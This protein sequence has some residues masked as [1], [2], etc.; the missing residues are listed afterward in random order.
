MNSMITPIDTNNNGNYSAK[1]QTKNNSK[2]DDGFT[3]TL[4][5]AINLSSTKYLSRGNESAQKSA[6]SSVQNSKNAAVA[7]AQKSQNAAVSFA[8]N[9]KNAG[10]SS[11]NIKAGNTDAAGTVVNLQAGAKDSFSAGNAAKSQNAD[12]IKI[13]SQTGKNSANTLDDSLSNDEKQILNDIKDVFKDALGVSD[14]DLENAMS[15]LGMSLQDLLN[16]GKLANLLLN[17]TGNANSDVSLILTDSSFNDIFSKLN[18]ISDAIMSLPADITINMTETD[19]IDI[20]GMDFQDASSENLKA[21]QD[22]V[23]NGQDSKAGI[24]KIAID[25][26]GFQKET[27]A[28]DS[29]A[30]IQSDVNGLSNAED[31]AAI[32]KTEE[33]VS[34]SAD[35]NASNAFSGAEDDASKNGATGENSKDSLF[36]NNIIKPEV[37]NTTSAQSVNVSFTTVESQ[38]VMQFRTVSGIDAA[39]LI[40]QIVSHARTTLSDTVKSMEMELNPQSLGKMLMKVTEQAGTVS[41]HITV[42][43]EDVKEA[44]SNQMALLKTNLEAQGM[45]VD[46]VTV[47][48]DSHA[49]ERNLEEGQETNTNFAENQQNQSGSAEENAYEENRRKGVGS[50]NLNNMTGSDLQNLSEEELLQAQIM[51]DNGNRMNIGA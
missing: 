41:A 32:G 10:I 5:F 1:S 7:S 38:A 30:N 33:A 19:G 40:N 35:E 18:E 44:L 9:P 15:D 16:P 14:D 13:K 22:L 3:D 48:A 23:N 4:S 11:V 17:L 51:K 45:K 6:V 12:S 46:E 26:S 29:A 47:T 2:R 31:A 20:S 27:G 49:F 21:L 37:I 34:A 28:D 24:E 8:Q 50:L 39:D 43:N 42:Q 25:I 36:E